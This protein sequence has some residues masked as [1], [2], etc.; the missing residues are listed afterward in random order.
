MKLKRG[1]L[2]V[3]P[4]SSASSDIAFILIIFFLV[5]ASVQP[6][7]GHDQQLPRAEPEED[8]RK[9]TK[10][11]EV[12]ITSN[13][14]VLNGSPLDPAGFESRLVKELAERKREEDKVVV[15]KSAPKTPYTRWIEISR[16][17]DRAGGMLTLEVTEERS[18]EVR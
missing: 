2:L 1:K 12:S 10:N 6:E 8:Q 17:I 18:V 14:I 5:C 16:I 15:L 3:D 4:P 7:E 13:S 9:Q 11:L